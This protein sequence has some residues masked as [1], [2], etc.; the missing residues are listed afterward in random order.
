MANTQNIESNSNTNKYTFIRI[1]QMVTAQ[2]NF[3]YCVNVLLIF[4]CIVKITKFNIQHRLFFVLFLLFFIF[5]RFVVSSF[6]ILFY[7]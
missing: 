1:Q 6:K 4:E 7:L 2:C 5:R 3:Q